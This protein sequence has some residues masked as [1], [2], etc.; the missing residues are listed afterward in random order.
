MY[1]LCVVLRSHGERANDLRGAFVYAI[2]LVL[3]MQGAKIDIGARLLLHYK[4]LVWL[5]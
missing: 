5:H 2:D 1:R 3:S 4:Y